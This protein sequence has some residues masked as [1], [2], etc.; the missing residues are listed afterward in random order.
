MQKTLENKRMLALFRLSLL[1]MLMTSK[2]TESPVLLTRQGTVVSLY[3][4]SLKRM[5]GSDRTRE[6]S[7]EPLILLQGYLAFKF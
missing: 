2:K 5:K 3:K 1:D 4:V 7:A 6:R